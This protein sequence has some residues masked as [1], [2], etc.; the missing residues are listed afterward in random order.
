[1]RG[2]NDKDNGEDYKVVHNTLNHDDLRLPE[3]TM[4]LNNQVAGHF[5]GQNKSNL[6]M[7]QHC[8]S[9][10]VLKPICDKRSQRELDFYSLVWN[11][12]N[13]DSAIKKL[14]HFVPKFNGIFQ[15]SSQFIRLEDV[16][17]DYPNPSIL[18]I[19]VGLKTYDPEAS[20][21]KINSETNK[22]PWTSQLGFR[23]LGMRVSFVHLAESNKF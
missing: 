5:F 17:S 20:E 14:Q 7:L 8:I 3:N 18:D 9:G 11:S 6:G 19:K 16:T 15:D 4:P 2:N 22:Y 13:G 12:S 21:E 1:M 10:D 23:V